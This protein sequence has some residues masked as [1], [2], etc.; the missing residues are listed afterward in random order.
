V[1]VSGI[2]F[3]LTYLAE[4]RQLLYAVTR[5]QDYQWIMVRI[6]RI[7]ESIEQDIDI[8]NGVKSNVVPVLTEL[9]GGR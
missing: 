5:P 3:K 1:N 2:E 4:L 7:C 9:L 6:K 8:A